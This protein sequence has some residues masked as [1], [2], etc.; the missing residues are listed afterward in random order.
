MVGTPHMHSYRLKAAVVALLAVALF[1]A[2]P[3][4]L[5]HPHHSDLTEN[6]RCAVCL[7]ASAHV[8]PTRVVLNLVPE[9]TS[10]SCVHTP[11]DAFASRPRTHTRNEARTNVRIYPHTPGAVRR[12][13]S[14]T[15][16]F[17]MKSA[18]SARETRTVQR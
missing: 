17:N 18:T 12:Y 15:S 3:F 6:T 4:L 5:E 13:V 9:P 10:F 2:T 16:W 8:T 7:V 1:V 11:D 14:D